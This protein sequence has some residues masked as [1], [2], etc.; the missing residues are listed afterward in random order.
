VLRASKDA[1]TAGVGERLA[2]QR[3][4]NIG[5]FSSH[6]EVTVTTAASTAYTLDPFGS[7]PAGASVD[8]RCWVDNGIS[9]TTANDRVRLHSV[10]FRYEAAQ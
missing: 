10:E 7:Y 8:L 1:N 3:A 4:I 5:G 9:G 2:C 6:E